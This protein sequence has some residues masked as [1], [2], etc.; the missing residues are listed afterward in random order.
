MRN[1]GKKDSVP[2]GPAYLDLI[3][4]RTD[5]LRDTASRTLQMPNIEEGERDNL[6]LAL[7]SLGLIDELV[8]VIR[9]RPDALVALW[10]AMGA[11][12]I[13][14]TRGTENPLTEKFRRDKTAQSTAHAR[15]A[16]PSVRNRDQ[17]NEVVARHVAGCKNPKLVALAG[18][19]ADLKK[20]RLRPL[21][22]KE[23][24]RKRIAR[25]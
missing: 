10:R 21:P 13:I 6:D 9:K 5:D 23:A 19:N 4:L 22:S 18:V 11:V 16:K 25:L 8:K 20:L 3:R 12:Y 14:G 24:L 17:I 15:N 2:Y 7:K 1:G